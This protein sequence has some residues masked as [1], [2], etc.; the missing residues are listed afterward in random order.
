[1]TQDQLRQAFGELNG[2]RDTALYFL[3]CPHPL[4]VSNALLIPEE[5]DEVVKLTDGQKVYLIDAERIA[6]VEI[7]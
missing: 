2:E 1:M 7:G 5:P 6:W 3:Q 4:V